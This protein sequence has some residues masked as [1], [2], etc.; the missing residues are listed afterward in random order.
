MSGLTPNSVQDYRFQVRAAGSF[1]STGAGMACRANHGTSAACCGQSGVIEAALQCP[2]TAPTCTGYDSD[3]GTD[4]I[5]SGRGAWSAHGGGMVSVY[6]HPTRHP[7]AHAHMCSRGTGV[8]L[9]H[10]RNGLYF[11]VA[12]ATSTT[13]RS[14]HPRAAVCTLMRPA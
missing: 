2:A 12:L 14:S 7:H 10:C 1:I 13:S 8:R 4:G 6:K 5:C 9:G 11:Q 3:I